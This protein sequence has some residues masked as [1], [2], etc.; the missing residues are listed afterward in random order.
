MEGLFWD[1]PVPE[2]VRNT[3]TKMSP[4]TKTMSPAI[5]QDDNDAVT[6]ILAMTDYTSLKAEFQKSVVYEKAADGTESG[7][8]VELTAAEADYLL[9][10]IAYNDAR[11]KMVGLQW[12]QHEW[13]Q[14]AREQVAAK[15]G[16]SSDQ[17]AAT[18]LKKKSEYRRTGPRGPRSSPP[19]AN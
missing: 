14:G 2:A 3:Q 6:A 15:F 10:E 16:K 1:G 7:I 19:A 13:V 8:R 11:D 17:Y 4:N 9:K 12:K 5:L 18:G